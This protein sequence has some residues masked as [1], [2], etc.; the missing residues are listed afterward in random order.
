MMPSLRRFRGTFS[1]C[2]NKA[3]GV[4]QRITLDLHGMNVAVAHGAFMALQQ[5]VLS[6]GIERALGQQYGH[7]HWTG[8]KS[9]RTNAAMLRQR[10]CDARR[11]WKCTSVPRSMGYGRGAI[12]GRGA[13]MRRREQR[14]LGCCAL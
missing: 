9:L 7:C 13:L 14:V 10:Y 6:V 8:R 1:R 4:E 3:F 5:E 11:S 2:L 12:R